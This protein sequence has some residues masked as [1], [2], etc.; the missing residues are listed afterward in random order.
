MNKEELLN[1]V[2]SLELP[3]QEYFI[4]SG[5]ALLMA[6]LRK[7]TNDLDIGITKKGLEILKK[8]YSLKL[9]NPVIPKYE[10]TDKIECMIFD[11]LD[12]DI[13]YIDNYPCESLISIYNFKNRINRE[14]DRA[15]ILAIEKVL[16]TEPIS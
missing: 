14:N 15:D 6:G 9:T 13:Q 4:L 10:I 2:D 16:N 7:S 1:L 11:K 8:K 5:G 3:K 12:T